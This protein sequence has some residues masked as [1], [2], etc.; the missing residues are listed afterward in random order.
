MFLNDEVVVQ[1]W[2]EA[3]QLEGVSELLLDGLISRKISIDSL[4]SSEEEDSKSDT[5]IAAKD[6]KSFDSVEKNNIK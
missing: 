4:A 6:N 1:K 2:K 5:T 3:L